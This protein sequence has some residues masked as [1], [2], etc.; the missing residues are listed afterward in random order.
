MAHLI[1]LVNSFL[2]EPHASLLNGI[3]LGRP[4]F[5]TNTFYNQLKDVGLIHI[6]VLSGMN[7]TLLTAI[8][9]NTIVQYIG[10]KIASI[11]TIVIIILFVLFVGAEAPIVRAAMMGILSLVGLLYGRKT[12]AL[13]LLFLSGLIM[14]I[15]NHEWLSSISFQLSFAATLGIILF[16]SVPHEDKTIQL[17]PK[18]NISKE[19]DTE[20][21]HISYLINLKSY[22]LEELRISFSAQVFTLPIIFWYFRQISF[23]SPIANILVAW[24]IAPIMILGILTIILGMISWHLGFVFS[25]LLYPLLGFIVWV[26]EIFSKIPYA[27]VRL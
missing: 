19:N 15:V 14:I 25:L 20:K 21:N 6:V 26:V 9:M 7:I 1:E 4:L 16:G 12:I 17:T 3:L 27:S 18:T 11:L 24:L 5:V 22:F 10:R 13:Y 23:I 2:P 8:I